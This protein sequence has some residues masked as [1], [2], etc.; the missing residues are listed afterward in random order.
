VKNQFRFHIL[1]LTT[2][3][4]LVQQMLWPRMEEL[5]RTNPA[6]IITDVDPMQVM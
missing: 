5:A 4:G 3:A 1:L 6:E 2:K